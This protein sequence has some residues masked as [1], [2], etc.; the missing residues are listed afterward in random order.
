MRIKRPSSPRFFTAASICE[1]SA[2]SVSLPMLS[3]VKS[4]PRFLSSAMAST[5][6]RW[7]FSARKFATV[8]SSG[9]FIFS[10][11]GAFSMAA[12]RMPSSSQ[13]LCTTVARPCMIGYRASAV[14]MDLPEANRYRSIL[15][16][17]RNITSSLKKSALSMSE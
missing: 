12:R 14:S 4:S 17:K 6:R 15:S 9:R 5:W 10:V 8:S 1:I 7:F 2:V 16:S 3:H 11:S 13:R